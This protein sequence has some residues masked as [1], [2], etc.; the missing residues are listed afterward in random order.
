M[1]NYALPTFTVNLIK[2][3]KEGKD[4]E[5]KIQDGNID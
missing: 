5:Y 2:L 4:R 1:K 3:G